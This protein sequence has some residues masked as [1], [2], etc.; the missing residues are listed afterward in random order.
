[1]TTD[2]KQQLLKDISDAFDKVQYG[3]IIIDIRGPNNPMDLVVENRTRYTRNLVKDTRK[4][5]RGF[6]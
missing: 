1:M 6:V 5:G 3:R 2:Y 4:L